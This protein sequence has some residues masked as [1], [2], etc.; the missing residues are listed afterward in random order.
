MYLYD[1]KCRCVCVY[2]ILSFGLDY[3]PK[4]DHLEAW[5]GFCICWL[6]L[7]YENDSKPSSYV[8]RWNVSRLSS[9]VGGCFSFKSWLFPIVPNCGIH[10]HRHRHHFVRSFILHA[11]Q[12]KTIQFQF[13]ISNPNLPNDFTSFFTLSD[14]KHWTRDIHTY[15]YYYYFEAG[16]W[17]L[18]CS[19][20]QKV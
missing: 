17:T 1:V 19:I 4:S 11:S 6:E 2:V 20:S 10:Q 12:M 18:N 9:R 16:S 3:D 8:Y 5:T 14:P 13:P 15:H 7:N